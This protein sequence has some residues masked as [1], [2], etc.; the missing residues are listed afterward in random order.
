MPK[1]S[2]AIR[3][4]GEDLVWCPEWDLLVYRGYKPGASSPHDSLKSNLCYGRF[5]N[6]K[7]QSFELTDFDNKHSAE[8]WHIY[9]FE[10]TA[11][12]AR[13]RG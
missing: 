4:L 5:P 2:P 7:W 3:L 11:K 8:S 12:R 13:F 1:V 9:G 6:E 10:W